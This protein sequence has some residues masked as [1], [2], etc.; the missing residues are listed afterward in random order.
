MG[1]K[2]DQLASQFEEANNGLLS[3]ISGLSDEQWTKTCPD[4]GWS[5]GVTA[6]HVAESLGTLTGLVQG[7][8]AGAAVPPIT[9]DGLNAGNAEHAARAAGVTRDETATLLR[10]NI[11]S[12]ASA[13]RGLSDDQLDKTATLPMGELTAA[14]IV[15]MIMIGHTQMHIGGI[16]AAAE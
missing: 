13:I 3:L 12:A 10:D 16:K 9:M 8:A 7:V 5:I 4:E 11:K 14:Q 1:S 2:S 6:H 15:E